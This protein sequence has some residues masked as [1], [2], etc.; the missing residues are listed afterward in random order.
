MQQTQYSITDRLLLAATAYDKRSDEFAVRSAQACRDLVQTLNRFGRFKSPA[1]NAYALKL[2]AW[3]QPK[4]EP[5]VI[6][7]EVDVKV[8]RTPA[9]VT[10]VPVFRTI[11]ALFGPGRL[12]KLDFGDIRLSLKN[13]NSVIWLFAADECCGKMDPVTGAVSMF[14]RATRDQTV[15]LHDKLK[16]I[17]ADPIG[18][19]KRYGKETGTC[20]VCSRILTNPESIEE[21]IGPICAT[22]MEG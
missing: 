3:S 16:A 9:P 7:P 22:R 1:Q 2:I 8:T 5:A 14:K 20:C 4:P 21:G 18:E 11:A 15:Q 19:A 17:E 12:A 13:D 6:C 10:A